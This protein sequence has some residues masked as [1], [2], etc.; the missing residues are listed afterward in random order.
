MITI[1]KMNSMQ[2]QP[3]KNPP[4]EQDDEWPS[5]DDIAYEQSA[6]QFAADRLSE[7]V[8]AAEQ[9]PLK[10]IPV[11]HDVLNKLYLAYL[12]ALEIAKEQTQAG[13]NIDGHVFVCSESLQAAIVPLVE[14]NY[15]RIAEEDVRRVLA[16]CQQQNGPA[17]P[18][19]SAL[20]H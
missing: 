1:S 2:Y 14:A 16:E 3:M 12:G 4:N 9:S 7:L 20:K 13:V 10:T 5:T 19:L 17:A 8:E 11:T 18:D 6:F 15:R